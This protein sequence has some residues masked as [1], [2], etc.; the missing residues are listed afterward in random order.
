MNVKDVIRGSFGRS[1]MVMTMLLS[2]LS[3]ADILQR[4]APGANHIAWQ[5]GH[6][7]GSFKFFGETIKV[8]SMPELPEG[9]AEQHSKETAGDDDPAGFLSKDQYVTLLDEQRA[10]LL[11]LMSELDDE[12]LATDSPEDV[13]P[14]APQYVDMIDLAAEHELM[15]SGQISVLRRKLGKPVAF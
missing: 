8:G 15:H 14:Y 2:D 5:L 13:R 12:E 9:F 10:A 3:D 4:P 1:Q 6:L 11:Q 7:I